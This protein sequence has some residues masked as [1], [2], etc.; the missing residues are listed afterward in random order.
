MFPS[1]IEDYNPTESERFLYNKLKEELPDTYRVFYSIRWFSERDGVRIDSES[2]FL[3]LDPKFGYLCIE[4]KGGREINK[5]G[6]IW[7][8]I[9]SDNEVRV[10]NRSPYKQAEESMRFFKEYYEEQFRHFYNGIYGYAVAFPNFNIEE[11]FGPGES[12][13][14]TLDFNDMSNLE[15][16]IK[17]IFNYWRGKNRNFL[18]FSKEQR[19]KFISLLHKRMSLSAAAGALI[20]Y[21]NS[22]LE[23]INRVQDNYIDFLRNFNQAYIT[24]GAGTG[25]TWIAIKKAKAEAEKGNKVLLLCSSVFLARFIRKQVIN[26]S[27]IESLTFRDLI[28]RNIKPLEFES[29][30]HSNK[31]LTGV[32]DFIENNENLV[33]YD[34]IIIDEGQDFTT[35]WAYC[36][37]HFLKDQKESTLYVFYDVCQNIYGRDFKDEFDIEIPPFTLVENLRNTSNIYKWAVSETGLGNDVKPNTIEGSSPDRY[38]FKNRQSARNRLERI[39]RELVKKERVNN[40]NVTIV[41]NTNIEDSI[42]SG[43]DPLGNWEFN[44]TGDPISSDE[45]RYRTIEEFKGLESDVVIYLNHGEK[46]EAED[47]YVAY[48]RA[49]FYLYEIIIEKY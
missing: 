47:L 26:S 9:L 18:A 46:P 3:I 13:I 21:R 8:L 29:I 23:I 49:R 6:T 40:R 14:L 15:Y 5:T 4:V 37:K 20:E 19:E 33:K 25:K 31:E 1:S 30:D 24:G 36:V 22:Q 48:T 27:N 34:A 42:I 35:E 39:L 10:L 2:D 44:H 11:D 45:I 7:K 32:S 28:K 38:V 43:D 41:S 17:E 16:R 12:K